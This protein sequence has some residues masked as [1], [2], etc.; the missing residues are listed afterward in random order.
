MFALDHPLAGRRLWLRALV[1][2]ALVVA[3]LVPSGSAEAHTGTC[4]TDELYG[5][6]PNC[7]AHWANFNMLYHWNGSLNNAHHSGERDRFA[8]AT[9]SWQNQFAAGP[10]HVHFN[11]GAPTH[12]SM[13]DFNGSVLGAGQ[14]AQENGSDHIPQMQGAAGWGDGTTGL[15]LRHDIDEITCP[16]GADCS[17]YTGTGTPGGDQVDAWGVWMEELG[18]AQNITHHL[19]PGHSSLH[20]HTM[21]GTTA[22]T[23]NKRNITSHEANHACDPYELTHSSSC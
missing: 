22:G 17:W 19:P 12:V 21:L 18:H 9:T 10:W 4:L 15:W 14:P 23:T 1:G 2:L 5:S 7:R 13:V 16:S 6:D 8:S 11:T 3:L 20:D